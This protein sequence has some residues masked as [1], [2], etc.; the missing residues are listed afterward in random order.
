MDR[1]D[2]PNSRAQTAAWTATGRG[3]GEPGHREAGRGGPGQKEVAVGAGIQPGAGRQMQPINCKYR[4]QWVGRR[5]A[6]ASK[7]DTTKTAG[8]W[9][10]P[11]ALITSVC[12]SWVA[13]SLGAKIQS[14]FDI[15]GWAGC[16][17]RRGLRLLLGSAH[18]VARWRWAGTPRPA[19]R[20]LLLHTACIAEVAAGQGCGMAARSGERS[21]VPGGA[22][23][24]QQRRRGE[25]AAGGA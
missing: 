15:K 7:A 5:S 17:P 20:V 23:R 2:G 1:V 8:R 12:K 10:G 21:H 16:L 3:W 24:S 19:S 18:S 25:R 11:E 14:W 9:A 6:T 13:G 22:G 4:E